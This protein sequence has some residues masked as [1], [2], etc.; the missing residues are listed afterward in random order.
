MKFVYIAGPYHAES[1]W[2]I[3]Q[4]IQRAREAAVAITYMGL[5]FFCPHLNSAH[6]EQDCPEVPVEHWYEQDLRFLGSCDAVYLL[7]GWQD[8]KGTLAELE[9]WKGM[10]DGP[11]FESLSKLAEWAQ[12][13]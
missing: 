7:P 12:L 11:V 2:L 8:S 4:H 9:E 5:G 6:F 1:H 10:V 13:P 3:D